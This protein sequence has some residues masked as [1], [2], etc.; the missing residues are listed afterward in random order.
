MTLHESPEDGVKYGGSGK[1]EAAV[2]I[3]STQNLGRHV[4]NISMYS[5]VYDKFPQ[6]QDLRERERESSQYVSCLASCV[7]LMIR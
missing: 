5:F 1:E 3:E 2:G 6:F 4:H 7:M